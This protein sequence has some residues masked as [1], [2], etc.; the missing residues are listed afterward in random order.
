MRF[1]NF[2]LLLMPTLARAKFKVMWK[3]STNGLQ[4]RTLIILNT[5]LP[6]TKYM[7]LLT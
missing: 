1:C 6:L 5:L 7:I 2:L 3:K 4:V